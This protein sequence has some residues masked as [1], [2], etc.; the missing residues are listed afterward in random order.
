MFTA[1]IINIW[2]ILCRGQSERRQN[3]VVGGIKKKVF[4]LWAAVSG[5][6]HSE[7]E[8]EQNQIFD[9][10]LLITEEADG[11]GRELS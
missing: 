1:A 6:L 11:K 3:C 8:N 7:C 10:I 5:L 2:S 4:L 9:L